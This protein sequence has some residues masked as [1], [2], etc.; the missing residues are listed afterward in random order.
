MRKMNRSMLLKKIAMETLETRQ[1]LTVSVVIPSVAVFDTN[2]GGITVQLTPETTP[3]TVANF[4]SYVTDPTDNYD[5][6]IIHRTT[7][8]DTDGIAVDQGGGFKDTSS[9]GQLQFS[10]ITQKAPIIN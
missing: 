1:M 10:H 5:G 8:T 6:T 3:I 2:L 9:N 7:H 4:L